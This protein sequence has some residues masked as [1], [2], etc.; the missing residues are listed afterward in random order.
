MHFGLYYSLYEWFN[1]LFKTDKARGYNTQTY[2][3]V[4]A[5]MANTV[6]IRAAEIYS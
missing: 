3:Q 5:C 2:V 1:P 6:H 4:G